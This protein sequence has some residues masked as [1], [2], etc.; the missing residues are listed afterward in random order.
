MPTKGSIQDV[1]KRF[2]KTHELISTTWHESS[3]TIYALLNFMKVEEVSVYEDKKSKRI[4][5]LTH[6]ISPSILEISDS[7]LL[8]ERIHAEIGLCYAGLAGEKRHFKISSGSD[9]F[10]RFLKE[11]SHLDI[12]N[13]AA[14]FQKY[15]LAE[16][17]RKRSAY[18]KKIMKVVEEC[19]I[20]HWDAVAI[21]SHHLFKKKKL[22]Y[23]ELKSLLTK[24]SQNKEFWRNQFKLISSFYQNTGILDENHFKMMVFS[25]VEKSIL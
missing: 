20:E 17:G 18:K 10:P 14:I 13:A 5:G 22:S 2:Q 3:H 11:G 23:Q 19:L 24:R 9:N 25:R 15:N 4:C 6:Y 21:I 16:P 8:S 1:R 7:E 12:S